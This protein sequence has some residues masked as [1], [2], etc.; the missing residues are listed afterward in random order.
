MFGPTY[1]QLAAIKDI[2]ILKLQS[3]TEKGDSKCLI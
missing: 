1:R 3:R 2:E